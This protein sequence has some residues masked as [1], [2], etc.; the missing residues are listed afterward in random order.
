MNKIDGVEIAQNAI[1]LKKGSSAESA[2][3]AF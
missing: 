3:E 1:I 2:E